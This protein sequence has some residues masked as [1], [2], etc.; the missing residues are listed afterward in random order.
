MNTHN[1]LQRRPARLAGSA[2]ERGRVTNRTMGNP[3]L[4]LQ[5]AGGNAAVGA[6]L[7]AGIARAKLSVAP[8]G[9]RLER[10]ADRA[11]DA[12]TGKGSST[13][14]QVNAG[15]GD[16]E[17]SDAAE[18]VVRNLGPGRPLE[19]STRAPFENHFGRDLS[20]VRVHDGPA[21]SEAADSIQARAFTLGNSIAFRSGE[22]APQSKQ[23]QHLLAHELAHTVQQGAAG[24]PQPTL[25]RVP[26]DVQRQP[27][28]GGGNTPFDCSQPKDSRCI[29]D[30]LKLQSDLLT[31][32]AVN[33]RMN[34]AFHDNPPLEQSGGQGADI[35]TTLQSALNSVDN[36]SKPNDPQL[37]E[38]GIWGPLTKGR[39]FSFQADNGIPPSGFEVGR[40]TLLALDAHLQQDHPHPKPDPKPKPDPNPKPDPGTG[41]RVQV[42]CIAPPLFS[43]E[44]SKAVQVVGSGYSASSGITIVADSRPSGFT[45]TDA[46]GGFTFQL[47]TADLSPGPHEITA[48]SGA[49]EIASASLTLPC[50]A[51]EPVPGP[52]NQK[53][54]DLLD[55][56]WVEHAH[57]FQLEQNALVR[58]EADL[59]EGLQ[60]ES[61]DA[62]QLFLGKAAVDVIAA[63]F[64]GPLLPAVISAIP[65]GSQDV[66]DWAV[67][68][69]LD[70]VLDATKGTVEDKVKDGLGPEKAKNI[71]RL[72]VFID[73]LKAGLV[74][75]Q[76]DKQEEFI[77]RSKPLARQVT[78]A[79]ANSQ[80]CQDSD[81]RVCKAEA[82]LKALHSAE[83]DKQDA[84]DKQY[85]IGAEKWDVAIAKGNLGTLKGSSST[86][87]GSKDPTGQGG[88]LTIE[89]AGT[90]ALDKVH[91]RS[92]T[93]SGLG[94]VA[95]E[96]LNDKLKTTA[97][98]ALG[99]PR[100]AGGR[101]ELQNQ[102]AGGSSGT[103]VVSIARNETGQVFN[104]TG[105]QI[106][107]RWLETKGAL[108]GGSQNAIVGATVVWNNEIDPVKLQDIESKKGIEAG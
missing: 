63:L 13:R 33:D 68:P 78:S 80:D 59:Q 86:D 44:G 32:D 85:T 73:A 26:G 92:A 54:E 52:F 67:S 77:L 41:P 88:V 65:V 2:S 18:S 51:P 61:G 19:S 27:G 36:V 16:M 29:P 57:T 93:L 31:S 9:D 60:E 100:A 30:K 38:D 62:L 50:V 15:T 74:Q 43:K 39:V 1:T 83:S 17:L 23:G 28:D 46:H 8:A 7:R 72:G 82:A 102:G 81:P 48:V 53:L 34:A 22:F 35:V 14:T 105:N 37:V 6:L 96:K 69:I 45:A 3:L 24:P 104:R 42:T 90:S 89:I 71:S 98:G 10:D 21:A 91:V 103:G 25:N 47:S 20:S 75:Q 99:F 58:L 11:A 107:V 76:S 40:K 97:I 106:G 4:L 64:G 108:A 56:I 94:A 49:N 101:V 5:R 66:V 87:L 70:G 84:F 12:I 95:L 79:T 55:A